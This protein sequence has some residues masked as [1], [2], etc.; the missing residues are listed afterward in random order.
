M[1]ANRLLKSCLMLAVSWAVLYPTLGFSVYKERPDRRV[2]GSG[3]KTFKIGLDPGTFPPFTSDEFKGIDY[4]VLKAVCETNHHMRCILQLREFSECNTD[5]G[6]GTALEKGKV[7]GCINWIETPGRIVEGFEFAEP[8]HLSPAPQLICNDLLADPDC[9]TQEPPAE[10][11]KIDLNGATVGF[12]SGYAMNPTCL[13]DKYE[14][15]Q[16]LIIGDIGEVDE[17]DEWPSLQFVFWDMSTEIPDG[18]IAVGV[19]VPSCGNENSL[20]LYPPSKRRWFKSDQLRR[21]WNCGLALVRH[22]PELLETLLEN[23]ETELGRSPDDPLEF[24]QDGPLPTVQ[25]LEGNEHVN[26]E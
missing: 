1:K 12:I 16:E 18:A 23:L 14:N 21:E 7:A 8:Y 5:E 15:F 10:G 19:E 4:E 13:A 6:V 17:V 11:E 22:S 25:C 26:F 24:K 2:L 3:P 20:L 9:N